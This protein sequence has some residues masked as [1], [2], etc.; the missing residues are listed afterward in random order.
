MWVLYVYIQHTD[1][2]AAATSSE[3]PV[4][5]KRLE[6]SCKFHL[7]KVVL[8]AWKLKSFQNQM[9]SHGLRR[10]VRKKNRSKLGLRFFLPF[11][12]LATWFS[13]TIT[14]IYTYGMIDRL[15]WTLERSASRI[16]PHFTRPSSKKNKEWTW[17]MENK[18]SFSLKG[19][20]YLMFIKSLVRVLMIF[21]YTANLA[22]FSQFL[23]WSD[24]ESSEH[25]YE[26][27]M[28]GC[29]DPQM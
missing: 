17:V 20:I 14:H 9:A 21:R 1:H 27:R 10:N 25:E 26:H 12:I 2:V 24:S 5:R 7:Q 16:W 22:L 29:L 13:P 19:C 18:V 15:R 8:A 23:L 3:Y 28:L 4:P 6:T 11:T